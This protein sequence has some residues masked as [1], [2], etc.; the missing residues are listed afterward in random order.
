M[1]VPTIAQANET[2]IAIHAKHWKSE[3]TEGQWRASMGDYVLPR[4]AR[5]R[6]IADVMV[7]L[8]PTLSTTKHVTAGRVRQRI[9]AVMK[10]TVAQGYRDDNPDGDTTSGKPSTLARVRSGCSCDS[11]NSRVNAI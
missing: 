7:V 9:G 3:R 2:V 8:L 4:L 6:A 10:W 11:P 5:K 1:P